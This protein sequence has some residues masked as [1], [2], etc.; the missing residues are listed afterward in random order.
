MSPQDL[1][2]EYEKALATQEWS[3]VEPLMHDDVCVTFSTGTF[4]GKPEVQKAFENNFATIQDEKYSITHK[5]WA[6]LGTES[7][8]CLYSF[9]WQ[10]F[11][12]G[13]SASGSGRGTSI[14]VNAGNT[15]KI[16]TEHLGPNAS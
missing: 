10:G 1:M 15:W 5:H 9:N 8:V 2:Q 13:Q 12:N 3:N 11:V 16:L 7:A 14:L 4:K 6:Y